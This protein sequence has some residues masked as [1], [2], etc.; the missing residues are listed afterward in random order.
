[1]NPLT[2]YK[3]ASVNTAQ[4]GKLL[5]MLYDGLLRFLDQ[6]KEAIA[7]GDVESSHLTLI[8]CQDIVL[9]LRLTLDHEKSPELCE[10]LE[11]LYTFM[12]TKLVDANRLKESSHLDEIRPTIVELRD[13]FALAERQSREGRD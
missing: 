8:R 7:K 6:S 3:N 4:P 11:A 12:Y 13:A 5:I 9:E 1:L 2:A 10:N